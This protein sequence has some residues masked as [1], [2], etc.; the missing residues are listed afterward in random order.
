MW[1]Q[2]KPMGARNRKH[3][4]PDSIVTNKMVMKFGTC[5]LN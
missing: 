1:S 5:R 4:I 2:L 3:F